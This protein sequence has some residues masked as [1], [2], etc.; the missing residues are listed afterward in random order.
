MANPKNNETSLAF[1]NVTLNCRT[2]LLLILLIG[3]GLRFFDLLNAAVIEM[4]GI[5]YTAMAENFLKGQ[6]LEALKDISHPLYA[7]FLAFFGFFIK[8]L[9]LA[10]RLLS[11]TCGMLLIYISFIFVRKFFDEK[12]ALWASLF[13]AIHPHLIRFSAQVLTESLAI[14]LFTAAVFLFFKGW[15]DDDVGSVGFSAILLALTY[16]TK[17]E[18]IM[19][20]LPFSF[21]LLQK[22]RYG[23]AALFLILLFIFSF[24]YIY[25]IKMETGIWTITKKVGMSENIISPGKVE[26]T[27]AVPFA[28]IIDLFKRGPFVVYHFF[29]A[30]FPPFFILAA[31]GL[32]SMNR[33]YRTL[34]LALVVLHILGRT[35]A[36]SH[37]TLR[38][39][40][41]FVPIML[42]YSAEGLPVLRDILAGYRSR[43]IL[44]YGA[45]SVLIL[46]SVGK[47]LTT[48]QKG[49][50]IHK[51]AGQFLSKF[52]SG[53]NIAE[54]F[55]VATYYAGG[56]WVNV[57]LFYDYRNDCD[58]MIAKMKQKD[59][60]FFIFD[61]RMV[62]RYPSVESCLSTRTVFAEFKEGRRFVKIYRLSDR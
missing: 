26:Y 36:H 45:L 43:R 17:T 12:K 28:S 52:A 11:L 19:Y 42:I 54:V 39:S 38:Y 50:E 16:L 59:V 9:E 61:Y 49:R 30:V 53:R 23:H 41:E 8:N 6:V 14:L 29:L 33:S 46:F 7:L 55:P 22:K 10:G 27:Y 48:L 56:K 13:V 1:S 34:T 44:Y 58:N 15:V 24:P 40:V 35:V 62:A 21:L 37:S 60:D 4:D 57:D 25:Y 18:Y 2:I 3:L 5:G 51:H 47:G 20:A 32:K 31:L